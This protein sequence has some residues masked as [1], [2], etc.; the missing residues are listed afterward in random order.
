MFP[1]TAHSR[2]PSSVQAS[3]DESGFTL[4]E[5]MVVLVLVGI[6]AA[7]MVPEMK[8]TLEE[9]VLRSASRQLIDTFHQAYSRSVSLNQTHRVV[10]QEST[11]RYRIE[12]ALPSLEVEPEFVLAHE[13]AG[14]EG[15]IDQRISMRVRKTEEQPAS[16][17]DGSGEAEPQ[18]TPA[19]A[20]D[21]YPDG[22]ATEGAV[23]LRDRQGIGLTLRIHPV[24]ARVRV[25]TLGTE[26]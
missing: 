9:A 22:T 26:Q 5:L 3:S 18:R 15:E 16:G 6:T 19:N 11:G 25:S 10:L 13:A 17:R 14:A 24:T 4:V 21:F 8:G 2:A 12:R 20:F 1:R 23:V 7:V